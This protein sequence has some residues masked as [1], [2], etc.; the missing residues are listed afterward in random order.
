[1]IEDF[2]ELKVQLNELAAIIN[3]FQSEAVQ[4]RLIE[5]ILG[6]HIEVA[7]KQDL[8]GSTIQEKPPKPS[9]KKAKPARK[10]KEKK[11]QPAATPRSRSGKPGAQATLTRLIGEGFFKKPKTIKE[12]VDYCETK[13]ALQFKQNDF[14]GKLVRKVR[15]GDLKREKNA[16]GLYEYTQT[17]D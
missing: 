11:E 16:D 17:K 14:S 10:A 7:G 4:I 1:M 2:D 6:D 9:A 5:L 8:Q 15:D 3:S 13:L 12:I